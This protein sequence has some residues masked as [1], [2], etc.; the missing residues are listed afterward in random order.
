MSASD[1]PDAPTTE[2]ERRHLATPPPSI[3]ERASAA[4]KDASATARR[5]S[6][7][8]IEAVGR[9]AQQ[10]V[11]RAL[12]SDNRVTSAREGKQLLAGGAD[13]EAFASNV[14]RAV[15]VAMPVVRRLSR[16]AKLTRVPWVMVTSSTLSIGIGFRT[17]ARELQVLSSLVAHRIEEATGAPGDPKLVKKVA[18]DLYLHPKRRLELA[19]DRVR[20]VRL[21]RKWLFSGAFGRSTSKR[22]A[23][24][25]EA[26]EQLDAASLSANWPAVQRR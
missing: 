23:N 16:G 3:R 9:L 21:T 7:A 17:G 5:T 22:A 4:S 18:I 24:A 26:A 8:L 6:E 20:L 10:A 11:D 19:D 13:T 25:L 15:V 12:L 2:L 1:L 14:Q